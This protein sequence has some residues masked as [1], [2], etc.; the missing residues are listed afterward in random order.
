MLV[1]AS[2]QRQNKEVRDVG[3]SLHLLRWFLAGHGRD[4]AP[5]FRI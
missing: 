2:Y 4:F 3:V 5:D 1:G